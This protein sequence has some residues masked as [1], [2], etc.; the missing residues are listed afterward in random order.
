MANFKLRRSSKLVRLSFS[1]FELCFRIDYAL[2]WTFNK[3]SKIKIN[4]S[5]WCLFRVTE[6]SFVYNWE[7][8]A[9]NQKCIHFS[10]NDQ[11]WRTKY[12]TL[13][14][15]KKR[16]VLLTF[17]IT[18]LFF[19]ILFYSILCYSSWNQ[20][21]FSS[22][23]RHKVCAPDSGPDS[24]NLASIRM[25]S[26]RTLRITLHWLHRT[27]SFFYWSRTIPETPMKRIEGRKKLDSIGRSNTPIAVKLQKQMEPYLSLWILAHSTLLHYANHMTV[28]QH[29]T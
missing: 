25:Q 16:F 14:D 5:I 18:L 20:I 23:Q 2:N 29:A 1:Q 3:A 12:S 21:I 15:R 9:S 19:V 26:S 22:L 8:A 17:L 13:Y 4:N 28:F 6:T 11:R 24:F 10:G 27:L 7:N